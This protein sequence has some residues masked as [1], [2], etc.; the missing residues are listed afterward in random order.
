MRRFRR[1]RR[2]KVL[3]TGAAGELGKPTADLLHREGFTVLGTDIVKVKHTPYRFRQADLRDF[4][5]GRRL[6][7]GVD[8]L[9]H[10]AN[11]AGVDGDAPHR[12]FNENVTMNENLFQGAAECGVDRIVF[13][14]SIQVFGS[15]AD[16]RT[17][18]TPA[19]TPTYPLDG[20]TQPDPSNVYALSKTVTEVMLRYYATRCGVD[21]VAV[22]LPLL[23]DHD[24]WIGIAAGEERVEETIEGF[25]GLTFDD[26]ASLFV[27]ILGSELPG[28]RAYVPATAH[29][30]L[31]LDLPELIDARYPGVP[32]TLP[33]LADITTI[34]EETGWRPSPDYRGRTRR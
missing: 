25:T 27:A 34:T 20:A 1:S 30:H 10:L 26:A 6:L 4:E 16:D 32:R 2:V 33:D 14:S 7:E 11:H 8:A 5:A 29:R 3:V 15:H 31:D 19:A 28:Y 12:V 22:R 18:V 23:H 21:G 24:S 13:A 9:V 17:V